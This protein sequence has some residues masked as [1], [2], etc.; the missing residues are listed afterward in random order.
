MELN[1]QLIDGLST[2]PFPLGKAL[3]LQRKTLR[4]EVIRWYENPLHYIEK[5][6]TE[7]KGNYWT[8]ELYAQARG[9]KDKRL[10]NKQAELQCRESLETLLK[11]IDDYRGRV[12][13]TKAIG[14]YDKV[15][16][17]LKSKLV[18]LGFEDDPEKPSINA[19]VLGLHP[20]VREARSKMESIRDCD[21]LPMRQVN[22]K[23]IEKLRA[24]LEAARTAVLA[25]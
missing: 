2:L 12:A 13:L 11:D 25:A 23:A 4:G 6:A 22:L 3:E 1:F 9:V 20:K 21:L 15:T 14:E 18:A 19:Y 16:G 8:A 17:D 10:A 5:E 7:I 24:E